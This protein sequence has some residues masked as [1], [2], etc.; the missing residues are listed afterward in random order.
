MDSASLEASSRVILQGPGN[1]KLWINIIQKYATTHDIWRFIDP[2]ED[3]KQ[4]LSKP[5]EPTFKDIN[6]EATS[7]AALTT[8]EFRRLKFLHSSYR[9]ELQTYRDQLKALAAL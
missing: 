4:A 2:T 3:E 5:K 8:E 1:W 7:L 9:S 6:P